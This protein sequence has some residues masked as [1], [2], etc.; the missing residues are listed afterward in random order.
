MAEGA[1][2]SPLGRE[3]I[4]SGVGEGPMKLRWKLEYRRSSL[5]GGAEVPAGAL[6]KK[7]EGRRPAFA[8]APTPAAA[9]PTPAAE[10]R[11]ASLFTGRDAHDETA[12]LSRPV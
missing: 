6:V 12:R 8:A 7:E 9:A 11:R 10:Q 1:L 5:G 4:D 2:S 3:L